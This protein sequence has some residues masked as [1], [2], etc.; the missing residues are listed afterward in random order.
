M[1]EIIKRFNYLKMV[2]KKAFIPY[3]TA[4]DPDLDG[5]KEILTMFAEAGADII[6]LGVPFSDPMADGPVIQE[7]MG[8]ALKNGTKLKDIFGLVSDFKRRHNI[9]I[10]LMGYYNPF[11]QY[12]LGQ[13]GHDCAASGVDGVLT[14]D[15]PPEEAGE[16]KA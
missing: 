9:P 1:N 2:G 6:E 4:G 3:I 15:M 12:G 8:R 10:V 5:T 13:F 11:F 14:V 16:M 7:A